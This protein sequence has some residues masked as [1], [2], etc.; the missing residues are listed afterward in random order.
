MCPMLLCH[1]LLLGWWHLVSLLTGT[2]LRAG[3]CAG[4]MLCCL[5]ASCCKGSCRDLAGVTPP[6]AGDLSLWG[7]SSQDWKRKV[8]WIPL[9]S[10]VSTPGFLDGTTS[11]ALLDC[12]APIPLVSHY[13]LK[14]FLAS[15]CTLSPFIFQRHLGP[16]NADGYTPEPVGEHL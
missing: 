10:L 8:G 5:Q 16:L 4:C 13:K 7:T 6:T 1:C 3:R 11:W 14:Q 12:R 2:A 15:L 9:Q